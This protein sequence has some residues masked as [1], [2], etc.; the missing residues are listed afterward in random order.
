MAE[1]FAASFAQPHE[2][3]RNSKNVYAQLR[4]ADKL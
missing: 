1:V 4:A 3:G 2:R